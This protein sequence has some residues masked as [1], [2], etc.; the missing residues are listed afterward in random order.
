MRSTR[1]SPEAASPALLRHPIKDGKPQAYY[2]MNPWLDA[3]KS[4][5]P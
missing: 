5:P 3:A 2:E 4:P 1:V